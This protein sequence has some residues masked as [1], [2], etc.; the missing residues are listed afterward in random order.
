MRFVKSWFIFSSGCGL[1]GLLRWVFQTELRSQVSYA[2]GCIGCKEAMVGTEMRW[3]FW[4]ERSQGS[5]FKRITK[6][7]SDYQVGASIQ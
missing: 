3:K 4:K 6:V 7:S 1:T 2:E 5:E